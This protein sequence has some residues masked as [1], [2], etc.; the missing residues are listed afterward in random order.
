M[1][2]HLY[3]R[4]VKRE[5]LGNADDTR[6]ISA[7]KQEQPPALALTENGNGTSGMLY[8]GLENVKIQ[9][10][11]FSEK[12][13]AHQQQVNEK[14]ARSN[15]GGDEEEEETGDT[16]YEREE[17]EEVL[18]E[19]HG[20]FCNVCNE[21][22]TASTMGAHTSS[23]LHLF[24]RSQIEGVARDKNI[25][26]PRSNK[27]YA[28]LNRMGW[29]EESGE[30]LGKRRQGR[31]EPIPTEKRP[32]NR[33][34]GVKL[35]PGSRKRVTHTPAY[36]EGFNECVPEEQPKQKRRKKIRDIAEKKRRREKAIAR[37]F[38]WNFGEEY[39]FILKGKSKS[40]D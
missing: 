17:E 13:Q 3:R 33:G 29:S 23:T 8:D 1:S 24:N 19:G 14:T 10:T 28:L 18:E 15:H 4:F 5:I 32:D 20:F 21:V 39:E 2:G 35:P 9:S 26:I 36:V 40:N 7:L 38:S 34:L 6:H 27:G 25:M 22:I 12:L 37:E 16:H 30:G 31:L 11:S